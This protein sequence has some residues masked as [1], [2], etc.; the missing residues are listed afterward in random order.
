MSRSFRAQ[1]FIGALN[2]G[3]SVEAAGIFLYATT[4]TS[5]QLHLS[6]FRHIIYHLRNIQL[7]MLKSWLATWHYQV[8]LL[9]E[10][11]Y[12]ILH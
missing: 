11:V 7:F 8:V 5:L 4:I 10:K 1:K 9:A 6:E 3:L 12:T 2:F